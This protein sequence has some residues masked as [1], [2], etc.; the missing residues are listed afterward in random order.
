MSLVDR[1]KDFSSVDGDKIDLSAIDPNPDL[2]GFQEWLFVGVYRFDVLDKGQLEL[3]SN[4]DGTYTL[5]VY[6][7][8]DSNPHMAILLN[9]SVT[10]S[11]FI[12]NV[13]AAPPLVRYR[14]AIINEGG[15]ATINLTRYGDLTGSTTVAYSTRS[16]A[17]DE[18]D[19]IHVA[20]TV[21]FAPGQNT[22]QISV[23]TIS[24][25]EVDEFGDETFFVQLEVTNGGLLDVDLDGRDFA[26]VIIEDDDR[27]TEG[28]DNLTFQFADDD[29]I[30]AI[31][32]FT[33]DAGI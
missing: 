11:D 19:Y 5:S 21:T 13:T 28:N 2:A 30:T 31:G 4:S 16:M 6:A 24:D 23:Q 25:N 32:S 17:A 7:A 8:G 27:P 10:T 14:D 18:T 20:G 9:S 15:S 12:G 3:R 33:P 22:A 26:V 29:Y 1:I